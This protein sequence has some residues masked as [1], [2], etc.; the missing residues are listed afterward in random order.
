MELAKSGRESIKEGGGKKV[1]K[2]KVKIDRVVV[3]QI[4]PLS[5]PV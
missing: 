1:V 4:H 3:G 5:A 2:G